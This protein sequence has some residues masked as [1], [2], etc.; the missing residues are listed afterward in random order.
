MFLVTDLD[1]GAAHRVA[2]I[3]CGFRSA[4]LGRVNDRWQRMGCAA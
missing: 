1:M 2:R 3:A 4:I